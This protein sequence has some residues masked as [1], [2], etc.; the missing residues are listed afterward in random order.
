MPKLNSSFEMHEYIAPKDSVEILLPKEVMH[1][2]AGL[3]DYGLYITS[4]HPV[5]VVGQYFNFIVT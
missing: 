4:D 3:G 5:T 2:N 1:N